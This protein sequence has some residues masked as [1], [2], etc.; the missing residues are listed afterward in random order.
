MARLIHLTSSVLSH[1]PAAHVCRYY[2]VCIEKHAAW[3]VMGRYEGSLAGRIARAP[4]G[5]RLA[6]MMC[7]ARSSAT[8][9]VALSHPHTL[10]HSI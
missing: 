4:P 1:M 5:E 2:G 10:T 7:T 9:R 8:L 6:E 3:L